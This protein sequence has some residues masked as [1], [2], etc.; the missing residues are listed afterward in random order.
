MQ[1]VVNVPHHEPIVISHATAESPDAT[2]ES[3]VRDTFQLVER[4]LRHLH[5]QRIARR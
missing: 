5:D 1:V 3:S 4:Q 2:M